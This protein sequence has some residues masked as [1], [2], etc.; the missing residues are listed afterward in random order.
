[1]TNGSKPCRLSNVFRP[2]SPERRRPELWVSCS[3]SPQ[4]SPQGEGETFSRALVIRPGLVVV[5]LRKEREAGTAIA[6]SEFSSAV[7]ALSLSL[8]ERVGVRGKEANSNPRRTTIPG[9]IKLR[10][11]PGRYVFSVVGHRAGH[12]AAMSAPRAA[13]QL[14]QMA[15]SLEYFIPPAI[16]RAGTAQARHPYHPLYTYPTSRRQSQASSAGKMPAAR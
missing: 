15:M 3:P 14:L 4:P 8:G 2:P 5:C 12:R 11:S 1:M 6:P 16:A 7:S 9:T 13:A 10:Q